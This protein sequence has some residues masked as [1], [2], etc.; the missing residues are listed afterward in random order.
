MVL[1]DLADIL[2]SGGLGSVGTTT[3]FSIY[4]SITPASPDKVISLHETGGVAPFRKMHSTAGDVVAERPRVQVVVRS[5]LYSTGR[6]KVNDAWKALEGLP[7]RTVNGTR[8]LYAAAVQSP[9]PIGRDE[10]NRVLFAFNL[11]VVKELSTA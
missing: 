5:M 9:F 3:D 11:D 6:Q 4:K 8:Y 1:D 7:E 10:N 2:S